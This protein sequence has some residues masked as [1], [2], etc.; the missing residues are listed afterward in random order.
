MSRKTQDSK[1]DHC[2]I[3]VGE[4]W[5]NVLCS[6]VLCLLCYMVFFKDNSIILLPCTIQTTVLLGGKENKPCKEAPFSYFAQ[7]APDTHQVSL[8]TFERVKNKWSWIVFCW[9]ISLILFY[10]WIIFH[11][12]KIKLWNTN[13]QLSNLWV[14]W[15]QYIMM[16][17]YQKTKQSKWLPWFSFSFSY[18]KKMVMRKWYGLRFNCKN[19]LTLELKRKL[20]HTSLFSLEIF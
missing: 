8:H 1:S 19:C 6:D 14:P 20:G 18:F 10:G 16:Q 13:Q 9:I 3:L 11:C 4:N 5:M 7:S 12:I 2:F 15:T 17:I